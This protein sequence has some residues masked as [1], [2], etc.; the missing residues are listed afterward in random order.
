MNVSKHIGS[1]SLTCSK[2]S[3]VVRTLSAQN[4]C[5]GHSCGIPACRDG[6]HVFYIE[7]CTNCMLASESHAK[8]PTTC[9]TYSTT[10]T[11]QLYAGIRIG[12]RSWIASHHKCI[13]DTIL[14]HVNSFFVVG[15]QIF[16]FCAEKKHSHIAVCF[17]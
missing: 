10:A 15:S 9:Y 5:R 1:C 16:C 8:K 11:K 4:K 13:R 7:Q 3:Q 14:V 12:N 6:L 2:N 17:F